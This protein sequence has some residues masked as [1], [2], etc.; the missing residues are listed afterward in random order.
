NILYIYKINSIML[1]YKNVKGN[2]C[3][4]DNTY[5][6]CVIWTCFNHCSKN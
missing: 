5:Q 1:I 4:G 6:E 3:S 2:K